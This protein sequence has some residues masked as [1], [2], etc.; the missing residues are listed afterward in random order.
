M[1]DPC[2]CLHVCFYNAC[3]MF[4]LVEEISYAQPM[5]FTRL[6]DKG[7]IMVLC[8]PYSYCT[9]NLPGEMNWAATLSSY[10]EGDMKFV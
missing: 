9:Y 2:N 7:K 10:S 8:H 1:G 4:L 6:R 3:P 5:N